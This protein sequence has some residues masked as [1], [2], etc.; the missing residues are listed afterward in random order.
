MIFGE[1]LLAN[2]LRMGGFDVKTFNLI[3]DRGIH[4]CK[5]MLAYSKWGEERTPD[6][7]KN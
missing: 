6:S 4:I 3:N 5:S 7:V 1:V 2:L